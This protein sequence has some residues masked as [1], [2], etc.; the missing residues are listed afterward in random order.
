MV[1]SI[2]VTAVGNQLVI[3]HPTGRMRLAWAIVMLGGPALFLV[4]RTGLEYTVFARVSWDRPAGVLLLATLMLL[5]SPLL[6]AVST[7]APSGG[8]S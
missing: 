7:A 1:F 5:A 2:V 4:A 3:T 8:S 6:A